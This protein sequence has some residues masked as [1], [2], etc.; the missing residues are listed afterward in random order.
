M[1][2]S[3]LV[4]M[5]LSGLVAMALSRLVAMALSGL[6]SMA[7]SGLVV[8]ALSVFDCYGSFLLQFLT[9]A[10]ELPSEH[11]QTTLVGCRGFG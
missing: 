1:P 8:M 7:L 2:L 5:A 10:L 3:A 9:S 6:V 11:P 4:A